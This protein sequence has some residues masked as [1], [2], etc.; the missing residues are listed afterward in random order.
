MHERF[1][2]EC[3]TLAHGPHTEAPPPQLSHAPLPVVV[4]II[5]R[6]DCN[7]KLTHALMGV[8]GCRGAL[9]MPGAL[10]VPDDWLF[11][12]GTALPA[13]DHLAGPLAREVL[14]TRSHSTWVY[15]VYYD[16]QVC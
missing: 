11:G 16:N 5:T 10:E 2:V 1:A 8:C 9:I 6:R 3:T 13:P 15:V 4:G 14:T 12:L 7:A